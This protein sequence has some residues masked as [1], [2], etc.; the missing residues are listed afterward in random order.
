PDR[1]HD[2]LTAATS[3]DDAVQRI[4]RALADF[5]VGQQRDDTAVLA[6]QWLGTPELA[7]GNGQDQDTA[8]QPT[9]R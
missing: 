4:S 5:E 7:T 6:V 9:S 8:S 1:L 2:A 3:A